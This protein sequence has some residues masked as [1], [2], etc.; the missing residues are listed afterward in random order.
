VIVLVSLRFLLPAKIGEIR[1]ELLQGVINVFGILIWLLHLFLEGMRWQMVPIYFSLVIYFSWELI[2]L[3]VHLTTIYARKTGERATKEETARKVSLLSIAGVVIV[4]VLVFSSLFASYQFPIFSVP[5]PAGDFEVGTTTFQ[6][7]D[8]DRQEIFT[9]D[10]SDKRNIVI[11]V[12]YPAEVPTNQASVPYVEAQ[13]EF[14]RGI[15][16][17]FGFPSL[18]VSHI[19]LV[20]THSYKDAPISQEKTLYPVIIFSHGYGGFDFQNTVLMEELASQGYVVF[21]IT[22]VYESSVAIFPDGSAVYEAEEVD[23]PESHTIN[24]S[25]DI[26]ANDSRFLLDQFEIVDNVNIP[27]IFWN[28]LD[29]DRIGFIGHSFGGTTAEEMALV[30]D[31]VKTGVSM[32]SPHIGRSR[33]LNMTKPFMLLFGRDYGNAEM[34]DTVYKRAQNATY[35]LFVEGADHYNFAD[36]NIWSPFLKSIGY[37]GPIDGY[38]MLDI[39]NVYVVAFFDE[40]LNGEN[41][42]LIDGPSSDYPEIWFYSKNT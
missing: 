1:K 2:K 19:S 40:Y 18:V 37:I 29:L 41:S 6:L 8:T 13:T 33:E 17:S 20:K 25:L 30:D 11:R 34:N 4:V 12:W 35:G 39:M 31:R 26:W 14:G 3:V 27:D 28:K 24:D 16:R 23:F 38:R 10:P 32:D 22:H 42:P 21:S 36:V 9:D 7:V 5:E 15:Q